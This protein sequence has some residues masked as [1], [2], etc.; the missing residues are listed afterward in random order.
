MYSASSSYTCFQ[1]A[2][3]LIAPPDHSFEMKSL[4]VLQE[5][6]LTMV[7]LQ[8]RFQEVSLR[9]VTLSDW[10]PFGCGFRLTTA[11]SRSVASLL[12]LSELVVR[13]RMLRSGSILT[14]WLTN[15]CMLLGSDASSSVSR[16]RVSSYVTFLWALRSLCS[17]DRACRA[18]VIVVVCSGTLAM[19]ASVFCDALEPPLAEVEV[20]PP[21]SAAELVLFFDG[22]FRWVG[23][24]LCQG[25]GSWV[26]AVL[27]RKFLPPLAGAKMARHTWP[28]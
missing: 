26:G 4:K 11:D 19:W 10:S 14:S 21:C 27:W 6:T 7:T 23:A 2:E 16:F 1:M 3:C 22:N 5:D 13:P 9:D 18:L 15:A 28:P 8:A 25:P 17:C 12:S 20:L 24:V